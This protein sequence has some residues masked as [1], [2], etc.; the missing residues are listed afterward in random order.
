MYALLTFGL[1]S[2]FGLKLNIRDQTWIEGLIALG[3]GLGLLLWEIPEWKK[4][5]L[6]E[7]CRHC[8]KKCMPRGNT[9]VE[10]G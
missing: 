6:L 3:L 4:A 1:S 2:S 5:G 7:K 10:E 9:R 8:W